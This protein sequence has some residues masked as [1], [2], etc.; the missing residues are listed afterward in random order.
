M[1]VRLGGERIE[2]G[3]FAVRAFCV[4]GSFE[5]TRHSCDITSG[6][7]REGVTLAISKGNSAP[8]P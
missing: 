5:V 6:D 7:P 4:E 8:H 3:S 2:E 1:E